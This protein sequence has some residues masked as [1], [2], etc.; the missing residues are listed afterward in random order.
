MNLSEEEF[1]KEKNHLDETTKLLR[2]T[3]KSE[4][5]FNEKVG[6][7]LLGTILKERNYSSLNA[8][9]KRKK[10]KKMLNFLQKI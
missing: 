3:I 9:I 4:S 1:S 7:N 6:E 10:R 5:A 8:F 2:D